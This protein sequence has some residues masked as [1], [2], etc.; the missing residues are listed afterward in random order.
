MITTCNKSKTP[1]GRKGKAE[2]LEKKNIE[3]EEYLSKV[4]CRFYLETNMKIIKI[5]IKVLQNPL[6]EPW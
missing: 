6:L 2:K 5:Y 3:E 4:Q 1:K